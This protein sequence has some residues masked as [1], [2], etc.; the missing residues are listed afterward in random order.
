MYLRSFAPR[1][2]AALLIGG[3][4]AG[5]AV[6]TSLPLLFALIIAGTAISLVYGITVLRFGL[7]P[8]EKQLFEP[9]LPQG[10]KK[11]H[12]MIRS[13]NKN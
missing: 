10:W 4:A 2:L 13:D 8:A 12:E 9:Y 3:T 5:I 11:I 7:T 1:A 6:V